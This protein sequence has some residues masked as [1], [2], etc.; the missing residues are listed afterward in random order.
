MTFALD[1]ISSLASGALGA[2]GSILSGRGQRKAN[3]LN[4]K[5]F[6]ENLAFQERMSNTAVQRRMRDLEMAGINPILAGKW[7]A[8][9]PGGG[10][11]FAMQNEGGAAIEGFGKAQ[12]TALAMKRLKQ[13]LQNMR[14]VERQ[15][16]ALAA[17]NRQEQR[18]SA[19]QEAN[20]RQNVQIKSPIEDI[21]D[22][23]E[24]FTTR[25]SGKADQIAETVSSSAK[26]LMQQGS[27]DVNDISGIFSKKKSLDY[28]KEHYRDEFKRT[29]GR[30][31]TRQE[32]EQGFYKWYE[33]V[34]QKK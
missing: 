26:Q 34:V 13:E 6:Q 14:A 2:F 3:R 16:L 12:T 20:L 4:Y 19:A 5:M 1:P 10:G 29:A 21:S 31:P 28:W 30:R 11:G 7:D 8:S 23:T 18:T 32:F 22:V 24:A 15:T 27:Q 17:K 9:S 33:R 25:V